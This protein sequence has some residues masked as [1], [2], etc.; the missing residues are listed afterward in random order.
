MD[1]LNNFILTVLA[2]VVTYYVIKRIEKNDKIE[3]GDK[4]A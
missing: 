3:N 4:K 2:N 1:L